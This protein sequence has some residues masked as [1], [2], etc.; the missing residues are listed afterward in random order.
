VSCRIF[1][2]AAGLKPLDVGINM[3]PH[4]VRELIETLS[5]LTKL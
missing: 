5:R 2:S 4:A 1:E 3:L